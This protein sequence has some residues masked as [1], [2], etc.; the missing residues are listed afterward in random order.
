MW[1]KP[2]MSARSLPAS[3]RAAAAIDFATAASLRAAAIS[4]C[5]SHPHV[6]LI[7]TQ[8]Q[9]DAKQDRREGR[10]Q[11][12]AAGVNSERSRFSWPKRAGSTCVR[13]AQQ[14]KL[15]TQA[16]VQMQQMR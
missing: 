5:T 8:I 9:R 3:P 2:A 1:C 7:A 11:L 13:Q 4:R 6:S 10:R 14:P 15:S 12:R 16:G